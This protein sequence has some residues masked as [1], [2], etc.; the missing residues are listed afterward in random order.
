[1][2]ASDSLVRDRCAWAIPAGWRRTAAQVAVIVAAPILGACGQTQ[3]PN[4]PL[5]VPTRALVVHEDAFMAPPGTAAG[6]PCAASA[7]NLTLSGC[8]DTCG[9]IVVSRDGE[10]LATLLY[11]SPPERAP[12]PKWAQPRYET[13]A[14]DGGR[15]RATIPLGAGAHTIGLASSCAVH[16][17][18]PPAGIDVQQ[19]AG[20]L[21][22]KA[23]DSCKS[24]SLTMVC[25]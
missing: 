11:P 22:V 6:D 19:A 17:Q 8:S 24:V 4:R 2:C 10:R 25:Q 20:A 1:M 12:V 15:D 21:A 5:K 23:P 14:S 18:E 9:P 13:P 7:M 3:W 16:V